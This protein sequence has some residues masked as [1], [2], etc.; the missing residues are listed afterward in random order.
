MRRRGQSLLWSI[1]VQWMN[2]GKGRLKTSVTMT[3]HRND[4]KDGDGDEVRNNDIDDEHNEDG[5][6]GDWY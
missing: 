4:V 1:L 3:M 6:G 5:D 2:P